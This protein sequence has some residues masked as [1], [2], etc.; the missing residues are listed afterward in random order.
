LIS[1]TQ[2]KGSLICFLLVFFFGPLK[3]QDS[4]S[5]FE[6]KPARFFLGYEY[7]DVLIEFFYDLELLAIIHIA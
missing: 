5:N 4:M 2:K 1:E 6:T 7:V 3:N